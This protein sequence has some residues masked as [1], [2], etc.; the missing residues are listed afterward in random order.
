MVEKAV[1]PQPISSPYGLGSMIFLLRGLCFFGS[2][3]DVDPLGYDNSRWHED[4]HKKP[5]SSK[6][7]EPSPQGEIIEPTA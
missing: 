2:D 5:G 7:G 3:F 1:L 4:V 6:R